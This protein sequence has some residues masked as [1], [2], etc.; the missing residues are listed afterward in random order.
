MIQKPVLFGAFLLFSLLI[1]LINTYVILTIFLNKKL[2]NMTNFYFLIISF[3]GMIVSIINVPF[4]S[5]YTIEDYR[6]NYGLLTCIIWYS[7][8]LSTTTT[9]LITF[10]I[11]SY[12]RLKS[13][14]SPNKPWASKFV[15]IVAFIFSWL[16]P[17]TVWSILNGLLMSANPPDY[18]NCFIAY[19]LSILLCA[20]SI[21]FVIPLFSLM[22][23]NWKIVHELRMRI[24]KMKK[25]TPKN[26]INKSK[27]YSNEN[28]ANSSFNS[29]YQD[30]NKQIKNIART[31]AHLNY[32]YLN[33]ER[34]AIIALILIQISLF[35]CWLPYIVILPLVIYF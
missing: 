24:K 34:K 11:I 4:E 5:I 8:D 26:K 9:N 13:I 19:S 25:V 14:T 30:P 31:T 6:W 23:I 3:T 27:V 28:T 20:I 16:L 1:L 35:I 22:I 7:I 17:S 18:N 29:T 32:N 10:N 15:R 2:R 21:M 12:I 33:K